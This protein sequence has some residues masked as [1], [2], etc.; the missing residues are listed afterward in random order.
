MSL[1]IQ[2]DSTTRLN[3]S[4]DV[5]GVIYYSKKKEDVIKLLGQ[6]FP[7]FDWIDIKKSRNKFEAYNPFKGLRVKYTVNE[8]LNHY[9]ISVP[10]GQGVI[11]GL[12]PGPIGGSQYPSYVFITNNNNDTS[13]P[14]SIALGNPDNVMYNGNHNELQGTSFDIGFGTLATIGQTIDSSNNPVISLTLNESPNGAS[15]NTIWLSHPTLSIVTVTNPA[16][17]N[18]DYDT[19]TD[20]ATQSTGIVMTSPT[21]INYDL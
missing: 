20:E 16:N 15:T 6:L 2:I 21:P 8:Y 7:V 19:T 9:T 18:R 3:P 13:F 5:N 10:M 4:T 12:N 1:P 14:F 17:G 11:G